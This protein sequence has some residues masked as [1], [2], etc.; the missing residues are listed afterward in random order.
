MGAVVTE[1]SLCFFRERRGTIGGL[2]GGNEPVDEFDEEPPDLGDESAD[3]HG[4]DGVVRGEG[5]GGP[6]DGK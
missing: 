3:G 1:D 4:G 5:I 6:D 2:V